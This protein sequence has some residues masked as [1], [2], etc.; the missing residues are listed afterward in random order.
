MAQW[1]YLNQINQQICGI[2]HCDISSNLS[3]QLIVKAT[4]D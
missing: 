2:L 3:L 4:T 1:I